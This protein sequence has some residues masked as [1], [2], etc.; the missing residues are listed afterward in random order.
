MPQSPV[1]AVSGSPTGIARRDFILLFAGV[2][3]SEAGNGIYD[4]F[5]NPPTTLPS[6][7]ILALATILTMLATLLIMWIA[8]LVIVG[9]ERV[10]PTKL[11]GRSSPA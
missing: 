6:A 1:D 5:K 8:Y 3:A 11:N 7:E 10:R 9:W 4:A 2:I